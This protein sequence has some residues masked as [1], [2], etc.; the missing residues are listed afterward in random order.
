MDSLQNQ[1]GEL[2]EEKKDVS[3]NLKITQKAVKKKK[4]VLNEISKLG[5]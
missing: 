5:A 1:R 2:E 3:E 4:E